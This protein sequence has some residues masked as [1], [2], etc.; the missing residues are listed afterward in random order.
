ME[1]PTL[2][3][4]I[5]LG[6]PWLRRNVRQDGY[7]YSMHQ[8]WLRDGTVLPFYLKCPSASVSSLLSMVRNS[9]VGTVPKMDP[10][11]GH[12]PSTPDIPSV[13]ASTSPR[14]RIAIYS[15]RHQ[16]I[17]ASNRNYFKGRILS[18]DRARLGKLSSILFDH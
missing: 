1:M 16:E 9:I 2:P 5:I 15:S 3:V 8:L 6:L 13:A 14:G 18:R 4:A 7:R 17:T 11:D 12:N 10:V